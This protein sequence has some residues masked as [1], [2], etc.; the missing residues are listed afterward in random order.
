MRGTRQIAPLKGM[1]KDSQNSYAERSL[2]SL[3]LIPVQRRH[4]RINNSILRLRALKRRREKTLTS[5]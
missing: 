2:R 5:S 4:K 1:S 3:Q